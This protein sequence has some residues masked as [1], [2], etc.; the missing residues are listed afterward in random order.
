MSIEKPQ[1]EKVLD[2]VCGIFGYWYDINKKGVV[3]YF[4]D[5]G[6]GTGKVNQFNSIKDALISWLPDLKEDEDCYGNI[7]NYINSL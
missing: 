3:K 2:Y 6:N 4:T 5:E 7:I 1:E